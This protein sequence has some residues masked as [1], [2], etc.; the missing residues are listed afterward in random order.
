MLKWNTMK[1]AYLFKCVLYLKHA[2]RVFTLGALATEPVCPTVG[3][4]ADG[5]RQSNVLHG[6]KPMFVLDSR[7]VRGGYLP[8]ESYSRKYKQTNWTNL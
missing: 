8:G 4:P 3:L 5:A 7:A 6:T 1:Y 2:A